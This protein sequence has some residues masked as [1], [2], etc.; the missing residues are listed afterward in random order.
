MKIYCAISI[1]RRQQ[2]QG[3]PIRSIGKENIIFVAIINDCLQLPHNI[4]EVMK[5]P[6]PV[7]IVNLLK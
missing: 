2:F 1:N 3:H 6:R 4:D 5:C 7:S